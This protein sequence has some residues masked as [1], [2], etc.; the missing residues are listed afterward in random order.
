MRFFYFQSRFFLVVVG[1]FHT[2]NLKQQKARSINS[3]DTFRQQSARPFYAVH[4]PASHTGTMKDGI[5][6]PIQALVRFLYFSSIFTDCVV[7]LAVNI[8]IK[9]GVPPRCSCCNSVMFSIKK[10]TL[11]LTHTQAARSVPRFCCSILRSHKQ[12]PTS[13]R[14]NKKKHKHL[15]L[16]YHL[17]ACSQRMATWEW[18]N[19]K[20]L[21]S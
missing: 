6:G 10:H 12:I 9:I 18:Q 8:N 13:F 4:A 14:H 7:H 1:L 11:S 16:C 17:N 3:S 20:K 19:K 21:I 2:T 15:T 5:W